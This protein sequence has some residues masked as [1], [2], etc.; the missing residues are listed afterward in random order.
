MSPDAPPP[1]T[2]VLPRCTY[3]AAYASDTIPLSAGRVLYV[4]EDHYD[5]WVAT[6]EEPP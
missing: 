2:I 1:R 4:C 6:R 3:C 5:Q